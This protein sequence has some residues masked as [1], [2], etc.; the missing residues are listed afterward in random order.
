LRFGVQIPEILRSASLFQQGAIY[1]AQVCFSN[2]P[3]YAAQVCFS[4]VPRWRSASLFQQSATPRIFMLDK[5]FSL[6]CIGLVN[7]YRLIQKK[8]HQ[9][10]SIDLKKSLHAHSN[11][12]KPPKKRP[13]KR[14]QT[15]KT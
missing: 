5:K 12:H 7:T 11:A 6:K 14:P 2:V 8:F 4:R 15:A 10:L 13:L 1:A 9:Y 3:R